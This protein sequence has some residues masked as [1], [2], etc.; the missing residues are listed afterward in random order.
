MA[1]H[2]VAKL[3]MK[4][5]DW[6]AHRNSILRAEEERYPSKANE[7]TDEGA[8]QPRHLFGH[9]GSRL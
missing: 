3:T 5:K 6:T 1:S 4:E 8:E 2:Y 9:K 7:S